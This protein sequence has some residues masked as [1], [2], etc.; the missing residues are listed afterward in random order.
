MLS[1]EALRTLIDKLGAL[2]TF[3]CRWSGWMM[4]F[5]QAAM[6]PIRWR[7]ISNT[8]ASRRLLDLVGQHADRHVGT[9]LQGADSTMAKEGSRK[10][11]EPFGWDC[12]AFLTCQLEV[13]WSQCE[14]AGTPFAISSESRV[15]V[16]GGANMVTRRRLHTSSALLHDASHC[17]GG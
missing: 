1:D 5:P 15:A 6:P 13:V 16:A 3:T 9:L 14:D 2:R 4:N 10:G 11:N 12:L 17:C 8:C 7:A